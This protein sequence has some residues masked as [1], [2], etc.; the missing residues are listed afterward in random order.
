MS[1]RHLLLLALALA[2]CAR[3]GDLEFDTEDTAEPEL[4]EVEPL[5]EA[6][7]SD[8]AA[9]SAYS[10]SAAVYRDGEVLWA[11]AFGELGPD[12]GA[13][14]A[15]TL[16]QIGST[17]K[18]MTAVGLLQRVEAGEVALDDTLEELLPELEFRLDPTWDDLVEVEHL[19]TH[20]GAF[21][22]WLDW[23]ATDDDDALANCSYGTYARLYFLMNEPG[24]FWN[25]S[26]PNFVFAGLITEELDDERAWPD[27][28]VDDVFE[29]LGM[30]R[31]WLRRAEVEDDGD[32]ALSWGYG[33]S[34]LQTGIQGHVDMDDMPDPGWARPAGLVWST[35]TQMMAWA[36]FLL[37]GDQD[38]LGDELREQM[39]EERVNTLYYGD[40]SH[41]GYGLMVDRGFA[42]SETAY[43]PVPVV[44]H[45]GNTLSFT[46]HFYLLPEQDCAISILSSG[47]GTDFSHSILTGLTTLCEG[48]PDPIA[49]PGV[50]FDPDRLDD[51]V[52]HYTDPWNV[53]EI[54]ISRLGNGLQ[55]EA[56]T[57]E[58]YGYDVSPD[59][60]TAGSQL[61]YVSIDGTWYDLTFIPE[62]EGGSS[63]WIRNR[64][65]VVTR[66][67]DEADEAAPPARPLPE[68][69]AA[70]WPASA[71][72]DQPP[73]PS[74]LLHLG[75]GG[76]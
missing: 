12:G 52:G 29:P 44:Q 63:R 21:Y 76:R 4:T 6:L 50:E 24:R 28:M 10:V 13:P 47:Y 30:G 1:S 8:L 62:V 32:F 25:Y 61:F 40:E 68:G 34:A 66:D 39:M 72:L 64:A 2:A 33:I 22:D 35:P 56:P 71:P 74:T 46:S 38:V 14:T 37:H 36:D 26:N 51:H 18:Q 69:R 5:I 48:L 54:L 19:L 11:D 45:G 60:Y 73:R 17:T 16:Y 70:R 42:S 65:F 9:S 58:Q 55:I 43:Y 49:L 7:R 75:A 53:G 15:S 67:D 41:Y 23:A 3:S 59:L 57:L 20:Q 31:T 27:I